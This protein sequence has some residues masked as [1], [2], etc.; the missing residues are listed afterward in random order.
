MENRSPDGTAQPPMAPLVDALNDLR[1]ALVST[2]LFLKDLY[3]DGDCQ[4]RAKVQ[5]DVEQALQR[6]QAT[7]PRPAPPTK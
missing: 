1:D 2:S 7:T 5:K 3:F 6:I 4:Q